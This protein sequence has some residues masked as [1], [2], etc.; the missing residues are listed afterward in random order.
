LVEEA[1]LRDRLAW[2]QAEVT[3]QERR[4]GSPELP[5]RILPVTKGHG[6]EAPR[7]AVALGLYELGENYVQECAAKQLALDESGGH[8]VEWHMLG[9]LQRNKA[10]QGAELF[11]VVETVDSLAMAQALSRARGDREPLPVLC[12]VDFT[13]L[14]GRGGYAP[15]RLRQEL[16]TIWGLPGLKTLGLMTVAS[17]EEPARCFEACRRLRDQLAQLLGAALPELSMGMSGDFKEAIAEGSTQV[18]VGTLLF[19][20]RG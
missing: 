15:E 16:P 1:E 6:P 12:E 11:S 7:A 5:V 8:A 10:R 17:R 4:R 20:P 18:R 14:P 2:L 13:G 9:H 19:G 3:Q